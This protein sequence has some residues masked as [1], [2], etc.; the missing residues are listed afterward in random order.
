VD[1]H[2]LAVE[3]DVAQVEAG[4]FG[5]S[6]ARR[7]SAPPR[8]PKLSQ[9]ATPYLAHQRVLIEVKDTAALAGTT[10]ASTSACWSTRWATSAACT[11]TS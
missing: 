3:V 2:H 8:L 1:P 9:V 4:D 5:P 6:E 10:L 11:S 7:E